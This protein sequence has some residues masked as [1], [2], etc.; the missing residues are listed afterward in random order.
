MNGDKRLRWV[1][2]G[3]MA[4]VVLVMWRSCTAI[5]P[6]RCEQTAQ[7]GLEAYE[8]GDTDLFNYYY[9]AAVDLG[10]L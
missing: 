9:D 6:D 2:W 4:L 10:C 3:V 8:D 1:G 5:E 7:A